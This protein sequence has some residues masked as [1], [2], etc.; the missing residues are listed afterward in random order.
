MAMFR[1]PPHTAPIAYGAANAVIKIDST[2]RDDSFTGR[3][4]IGVCDLDDEGNRVLMG[5]F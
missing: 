1:L 4:I 2:I 5:G 3:A